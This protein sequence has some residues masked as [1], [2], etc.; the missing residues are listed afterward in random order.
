M[1]THWKR[2]VQSVKTDICSKLWVSWRPTVEAH[3]ATESLIWPSRLFSLEVEERRPSAL[4]IMTGP[5]CV[6]GDLIELITEHLHCLVQRAFRQSSRAF[7]PSV[8]TDRFI[9]RGSSH[10]GA[11]SQPYAGDEV[12]SPVALM[13]MAQGI[14]AKCRS[15]CEVCN[16]FCSAKTTPSH[17]CLCSFSLHKRF[18]VLYFI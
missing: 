7:V 9:I 4:P 14:L 15:T 6:R 18:A 17:L 12:F 5:I 16:Y 2:H 10:P 3:S 13:L 8:C 1:V 11:P